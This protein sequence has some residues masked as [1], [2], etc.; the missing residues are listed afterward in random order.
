MKKNC[1]WFIP[2]NLGL[3]RR[4]TF[5]EDLAIIGRVIPL[6]THAQRLLSFLPI[7]M[8]G[9]SSC[10]NT[11]LR[12]GISPVLDVA[13]VQTAASNQIAIINA[14]ALDA[15]YD[16]QG[17]VNYYDVAQAGFN[18]VD[19]QCNAYF[20]YMFFFDRRRTEIQSGLAA[21]GATTG[22][23]LGLTNASAMSLG[24]VASAFGF[25]SNA[26]DIVAGTYVFGH[27]AETMVLVHRLQT[28]YRNG[29]AT[30]RAFI[31][32]RT[33]AYYAIQRYLSLCLPPTIEGVIANQINATTA[34][35]VS[36]GEG[37]LVS[38]QTG[39]SLRPLESSRPA[40]PK[41]SATVSTRAGPGR[42]SGSVA[43]GPNRSV[44]PAPGWSKVV[45]P[46][47][48]IDVST[49]N[50][51]QKS[52]CLPE[53][54][55]GSFNSE[56]ELGLKIYSSVAR[57]ASDDPHWRSQSVK[58]TEP[59]IVLLRNVNRCSNGAKNYLESWLL[60]SQEEGAPKLAADISDRIRKKFNIT[61][62]GKG[63]T[64]L[65]S[66]IVEWRKELA[67]ENKID[68]GPNEMF[69]NQITPD[70]VGIVAPAF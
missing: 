36:T 9:L 23:I 8:L 46:T 16:P 32:S 31:N 51:I 6:S 70:F 42:A 43:A 26:T 11:S 37:S 40:Q 38:V 60:S 64:E 7:V 29:A 18:Y 25:A 49:A 28:A 19:D 69:V 63:L 20:D 27:P 58:L 4:V 3:N 12:T 47:V 65:R 57:H 21:A 30:N 15:G 44:V 17:N 41:G 14:L 48:T 13:S 54:L 45:D 56:T 10:A 61:D 2:V 62:V 67:Q 55:N 50:A 1:K 33:S 24:I 35:S 52:L 68:N 5:Q 66:Q 53:S 39:S 22:A 59:D 34:V